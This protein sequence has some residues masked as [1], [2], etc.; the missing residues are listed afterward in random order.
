MGYIF[1]G[2]KYDEISV[3][4]EFYTAS[5]TVTEA[6]IVNFAMLS[7]DWNPLHTDHEYAEKHGPYGGIVAHGA[8]T[9]SIATGLTNALGPFEGN[10]LGFAGIELKFTAPV[11]PGDT[12]HAIMRVEEKHDTSKPNKGVVITSANVYNQRDEMVIQQ[13]FTMIVAR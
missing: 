12:I 2:K 1:K 9:F 8:L 13:N 5:R 3:G 10:L 6:D 11:R 4:D 7:G